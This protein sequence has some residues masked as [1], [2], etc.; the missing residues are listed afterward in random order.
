MWIAMA[1]QGGSTVTITNHLLDTPRQLINSDMEIQDIKI[2]NNTL[3]VVDR[4]KLAHWDLEAVGTV[5][6]THSTRQIVVETLAI[7]A[8]A[9]LL[10]LSHDCPQIAFTIGQTV[11]L[12][13]L[14]ASGPINQCTLECRV[15]GL[16]FSPDQH[17]LLLHTC[18]VSDGSKNSSYLV[19]LVMESEGFWDVTTTTIR[20]KLAWAHLFS[21]GCYLNSSTDHWVMNSGGKKLLWLPPSWR[22][23]GDSRFVK[24]G[25]NFLT[26]VDVYL[27]EPIIIQFFP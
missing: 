1:R 13:D 23:W 7:D 22:P 8:D 20:D 19:E 17:G 10:T 2:I 15:L 18:T 3:F 5:D 25:G 24:W 14:M 12:Q 27:P 9:D 6:S 16:Q 4:C 21:Y 26:L 11:Y